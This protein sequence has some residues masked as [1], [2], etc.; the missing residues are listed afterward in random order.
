MKK[1]VIWIIGVCLI[2]G[3]Y[4]LLSML[5]MKGRVHQTRRFAYDNI[6]DARHDN[7]LIESQF[8]LEGFESIE[9]E[10]SIRENVHVWVSKS[11][12]REFFGFLVGIKRENKK[13][14]CITIE[15]RSCKYE[16]LLAKEIFYNDSRTGTLTY[17]VT[18]VIKKDVILFDIMERKNHILKNIGTLVV[19]LE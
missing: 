3:L 9:L 4:Y 8:I 6:E 19:N 7:A 2:V 18:H 17:A 11:M 1:I 15:E 13:L 10:N 14:I 5:F 12:Y 16:I